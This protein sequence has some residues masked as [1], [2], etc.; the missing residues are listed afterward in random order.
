LFII[1]NL[2]QRRCA[3][4]HHKG[5]EC[6]LSSFP[7][8]DRELG[9]CAQDQL[10]NHLVPG[11]AEQPVEDRHA[12]RRSRQPCARLMVTISDPDTEL[13][14]YLWWRVLVIWTGNAGDNQVYAAVISVGRRLRII[15]STSCLC[16]ELLIRKSPIRI[17][18]VLE[19]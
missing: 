2:H 4:T 10:N 11:D 1:G 16:A 3:T 9:I 5:N 18:N 19:G 6:V 13:R 15:G 12:G 14:R 8:G 7:A 17:E